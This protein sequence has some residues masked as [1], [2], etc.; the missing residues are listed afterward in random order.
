MRPVDLEPESRPV[1]RLAISEVGLSRA[2][3]VAA[4]YEFSYVAA[5]EL[6]ELGSDEVRRLVVEVLRA[7]DRLSSPPASVW[8][9]AF[10][11]LCERQIEVAFDLPGR[12]YD[13]LVRWLAPFEAWELFVAERGPG[14]PDRPVPSSPAP[15]GVPA[16]ADE[17]WPAL[18]LVVA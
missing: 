7:V 15:A 2:E 10:L 16:D 8:D 9:S 14:T 1:V 3:L 6:A 13:Y 12:H 17:F 11:E 18:E 5:V 4:L